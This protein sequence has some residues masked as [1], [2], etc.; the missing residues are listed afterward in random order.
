MYTAADVLA[1]FVF[2]VTVPILFGLAVV[3]MDL[4]ATRFLNR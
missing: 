3:V 4:V 1:S 2:W